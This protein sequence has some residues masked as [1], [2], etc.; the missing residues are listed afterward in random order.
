M[1][2]LTRLTA[3][4][5]SQV[6]RQSTAEPEDDDDLLMDLPTPGSSKVVRFSEDA[7]SAA[8]QKAFDVPD[9]EDVTSIEADTSTEGEVSK[10]DLAELLASELMIITMSVAES[11][12]TIDAAKGQL[13]KLRRSALS[14]GL[15]EMA[16]I[17]VWLSSFESPS[18][19]VEGVKDKIASITSFQDDMASYSIFGMSRS[20][21]TMEFAIRR[22]N[23]RKVGRKATAVFKDVNSACRMITLLEA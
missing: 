22:T 9:D 16:E 13:H 3:E 10:S 8:G 21:A 23:K 4:L 18:T 1:V 19:F 11:V 5:A 14:A 2:G 7:S 12:M 6:A 15:T 20:W 17:F